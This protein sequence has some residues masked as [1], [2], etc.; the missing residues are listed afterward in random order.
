MEFGAVEGEVEISSR[1]VGIRGVEDVKFD[2]EDD[3][4]ELFDEE[5]ENADCI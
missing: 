2:D 1:K 3:E 4:D 5:N